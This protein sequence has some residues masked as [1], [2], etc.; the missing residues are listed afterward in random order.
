MSLTFS[1]YADL[2][3]VIP[4]DKMSMSRVT[5]CHTILTLVSPDAQGHVT[6]ATPRCARC[7][8]SASPGITS[9]TTRASRRGMKKYQAV[10]RL[11]NTATNSSFSDM[12]TLNLTNLDESR[13]EIDLSGAVTPVTY[14]TLD[15]RRLASRHQKHQ[16][17]R[18]LYHATKQFNLNVEKGLKILQEGGFVDETPESVAKFLFR[19][20][21]LSKKQ[22]GKF[23]LH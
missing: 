23:K 10:I 12:S 2:S 1:K 7:Q 22:I 14:Y 6:Q 5:P 3:T 20:E 9:S 18:K 11:N 19:Q 13:P 8:V 15:S 17:E 4:R 21:R 16:D